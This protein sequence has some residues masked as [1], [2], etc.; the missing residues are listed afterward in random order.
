M[1]F[2][3]YLSYLKSIPFKARIIIEVIEKNN[4]DV[5]QYLFI[6]G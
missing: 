4:Q 2:I 1:V 3:K 6:L 5:A